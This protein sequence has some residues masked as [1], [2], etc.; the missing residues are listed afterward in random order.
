MNKQEIIDFLKVQIKQNQLSFYMYCK[1]YEY[2]EINLK[3]EIK[4]LGFE[5]YLPGSYGNCRQRL[6]SYPPKYQ[7]GLKQLE[8]NN[9]IIRCKTCTNL[10]LKVE[11]YS[12]NVCASCVKKWEEELEMSNR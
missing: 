10:M 4:Q 6:M 5:L 11:G 7:A 2:A 12:R 3:E 8:S 1:D 9:N